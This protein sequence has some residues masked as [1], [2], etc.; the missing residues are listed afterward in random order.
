MG[1]GSC[2]ARHLKGSGH[3]LTLA[4]GRLRHLCA[5]S[6][7]VRRVCYRDAEL[8]G[9]IE[10]RFRTHFVSA[11]L[12]EVCIARDDDGSTHRDRSVRRGVFDVVMDRALPSLYEGA[13]AAIWKALAFIDLISVRWILPQ[14]RDGSHDLE[15]GAGRIQSIPG[16]IKQGVILIRLCRE[17]DWF[18][19]G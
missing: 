8:R 12:R 13:R 4:V 11:Q 5:Q 9:S 7:H 10:Q 18:G 16:A 3:H 17:R 1:N 15:R 6:F 2:H 19:H 14:S